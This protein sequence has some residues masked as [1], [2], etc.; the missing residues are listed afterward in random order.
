M[1]VYEVVE[2]YIVMQSNTNK[3]IYMN[4]LQLNYGLQKLYLYKD[5]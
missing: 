2:K 3:K 1:R 5:Q 4:A